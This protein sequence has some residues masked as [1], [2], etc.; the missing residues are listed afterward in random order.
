M[1]IRP[2]LFSSTR[3]RD[4]G[5]GWLPSVVE[6]LPSTSTVI[7]AGVSRG[8]VRGVKSASKLIRTLPDWTTSARDRGGERAG[9]D[10]ISS[11]VAIRRRIPIPATSLGRR[12]AG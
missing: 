7:G 4:S 3:S 12:T 2:A 9:R 8:S 1:S 6:I 10:S 5:G 11:S